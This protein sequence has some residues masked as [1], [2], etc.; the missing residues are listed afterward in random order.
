MPGDARGGRVSFIAWFHGWQERR[1][2]RR[3]KK[4]ATAEN[5]FGHWVLIFT[6]SRE[7]YDA[8]PVRIVGEYRGLRD[9]AMDACQAAIAMIVWEHGQPLVGQYGV[10]MK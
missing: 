8:G 1:R 4:S 9:A 2:Q 6:E 5:P 3:E 7:G 10:I